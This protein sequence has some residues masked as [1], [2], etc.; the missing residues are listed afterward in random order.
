M[1]LL[2]IK[3]QSSQS[4]PNTFISKSDKFKCGLLAL[5]HYYFQTFHKI[6]PY[7]RS[8]LSHSD[9]VVQSII[10]LSR[11]LQKNCIS[12]SKLHSMQK[13]GIKCW[14]L[15]INN[16]GTEWGSKTLVGHINAGSKVWMSV[17]L[18]IA[19]NCLIS[20]YLH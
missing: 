6:N 2:R 13:R 5:T 15:M 8:Y 17:P 14:N 11:L 16:C 19:G 12:I 1:H 10:V 20:Q 7:H 18:V 4:L 9:Y 3:K